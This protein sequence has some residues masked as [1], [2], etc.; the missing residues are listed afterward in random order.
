MGDFNKTLLE[1]DN[2][3]RQNLSSLQNS[4]PFHQL[5]YNTRRR[6]EVDQLTER[7]SGYNARLIFLFKPLEIDLLQ[8]IYQTV[9]ET[10]RLMQIVHDVIILGIN[11]REYNPEIRETLEVRLHHTLPIPENFREAF[12]HRANNGKSEDFSNTSFPFVE[13]AQALSLHLQNSTL[14]F[15]VDPF[16]P[17]QKVAPIREYI[18]LLK[19]IWLLE[20]LSRHSELQ[21]PRVGSH[22]PS[23]IASMAHE[24]SSQCRRFS[25]SE[26]LAPYSLPM[27]IELCNI[28]PEVMPPDPLP[29]VHEDSEAMLNKLLEVPLDS[30]RVNISQQTQIFRGPEG[31]IKMILSGTD[32]SSSNTPRSQQ[33][34][35]EFNIRNA[36]LIPLY[37]MPSLFCMGNTMKFHAGKKWSNLCFPEV[38]HA[39]AVQQAITGF[40]AF[41]EYSEGLVDVTLVIR[42]KKHKIVRKGVLQLWVEREIVGTPTTFDSLQSPSPSRRYSQSAKNSP[43]P[44]TTPQSPSSLSPSISREIRGKGPSLTVEPFGSSQSMFYKRRLSEVSSSYSMQTL[45]TVKKIDH[46]NNQY[47]LVHQ[48]PRDPMLVLFLYNEEDSQSPLRRGDGLSFVTIQLDQQTR[49]NRVMCGCQ[50]KCIVCTHAVIERGESFLQA[51]MYEAMTLDE[52]DLTQL[53]LSKRQDLPARKLEDLLRVS[54]RFLGQENREAEQ[55][56]VLFGGNNC[57]CQPVTVGELQKCLADPSHAGKFQLVKEIGRQG[58]ENWRKAQNSRPEIVYDSRPRY[59]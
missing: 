13:A 30:G 33:R 45:S 27:K 57:H 9:K 37:T 47:G 52:W 7:L 6:P 12:L 55:K 41:E 25:E 39:L 31:E 43:S 51:Q 17:E 10:H 26:I 14:D 28:W 20:H 3:I 54:I 5:Y 2:L 16:D 35:L 44:R 56:R 22:W 19:C 53:G 50:S 48:K 8:K 58:L 21:M 15:V 23:Y 24:V 11:K 36:R 29:E 4:G 1:C 49:L 34:I 59:D 18:N 38:R 46:G 42:G 40:K 32:H